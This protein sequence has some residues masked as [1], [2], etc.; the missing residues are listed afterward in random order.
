MENP[1][2]VEPPIDLSGNSESDLVE[3]SCQGVS[4]PRLPSP[5]LSGRRPGFGAW[6]QQA[7]GLPHLI[8]SLMPGPLE[9][10]LGE[11]VDNGR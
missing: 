7:L 5:K 6:V 4:F 2:T 1:D 9:A 11:A 3:E 10:R 8:V